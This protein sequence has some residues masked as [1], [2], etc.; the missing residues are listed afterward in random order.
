MWRSWSTSLVLGTR[1]CCN[2]E[3]EFE[4]HHPYDKYN[5]MLY[6]LLLWIISLK[7]VKVTLSLVDC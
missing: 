5:K 2:S 6:A 1:A 7:I 3:R 4:S